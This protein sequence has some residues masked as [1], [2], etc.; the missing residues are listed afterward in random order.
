MND[1]RPI[2]RWI[3]DE[4]N[5]LLGLSISYLCGLLLVGLGA[6]IVGTFIYPDQTPYRSLAVSL[7]FSLCGFVLVFYLYRQGRTAQAS[8]LMISTIILQATILTILFENMIVAYAIFALI[9]P[10]IATILHSPRIGYI[11]V[12]GQM[13]FGTV[14]V[15]AV[16]YVF[17]PP[18]HF[19]DD[20]RRII[21]VLIF[22][23]TVF[24]GTHLVSH[25]R[26]S[27]QRALIQWVEQAKLLQE[28][29]RQLDSEIEERQR[30]QVALAESNNRLEARVKVRT[31]EL[32]EANR[33]LETMLY[34]VSHDMKE[35]LRTVQNFSD[36]TIRRYA[37]AVD[38]QGQDYLRRIAGAG[39]RMTSL[40]DD[41]LTLSRLRQVELSLERIPARELVD[42]A[43]ERLSNDIAQTQATIRIADNLPGLP[44]NRFWGVEA[45][46]NLIS[47]ALKF[48]LP[49]RSPEIDIVA[50]GQQGI[51]VLDRGPGVPEE[52]AEQIF[53]LFKRNVGRE[54]EGTGA[55]LAIVRQIVQ[56][57]NGDVWVE[58][59]PKGGASFIVSFC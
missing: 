37:D 51:A 11:F 19:Q 16:E 18:G 36:L 4:K 31:R 35:P 8:Y 43:I 10:L 52:Q 7:L 13:L 44:L 47:N 9:I 15:V 12:A 23:F 59:R 50:V 6:A 33:E 54:I 17:P 5:R 57:H 27:I 26:A 29:N 58:N 48:T 25:S 53:Q 41:I 32:T 45:I 22:I 39:A 30:A 56:R 38:Q 3:D 28:S 55:G 20:V 34:V 2:Q 24:L 1:N 42:G 21:D 14:L 40:L 49:D 46:Y